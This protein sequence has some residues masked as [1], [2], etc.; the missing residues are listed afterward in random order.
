MQ[1]LRAYFI[2]STI[3]TKDVV[4][5]KRLLEQY[6]DNTEQDELHLYISYQLGFSDSGGK[7]E[8]GPYQA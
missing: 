8:K 6:L 2:S 1:T 4:Y 3:R 7:K 5:W